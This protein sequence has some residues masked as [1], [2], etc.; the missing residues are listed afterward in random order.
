MQSY[1]S[2]RS[3]AAPRGPRKPIS[4]FTEITVPKLPCCL[5]LAFAMGCG[6]APVTNTVVLRAKSPDG[7]ATAILVDR[8]YH[9]ARS[10]DEFFLIVVEFPGNADSAIAVRNIG[11]RAALVATYATKLQLN[12]E[13]NSN[14]HVICK[15]CGLT[16]INIEKKL[17]RLGSIQIVYEGFPAGMAE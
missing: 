3:S 17:D 14:L 15:S 1:S 11:G 8:A 2:L 4:N 9:V 10:S 7:K 5:L 16:P 13:N 6:A 12:W